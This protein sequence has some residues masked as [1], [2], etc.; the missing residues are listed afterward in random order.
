MIG[1]ESK[2]LPRLTICAGFPGQH[3]DSPEWSWMLSKEAHEELLGRS[4]ELA[5]ISTPKASGKSDNRST[6]LVLKSEQ[7]SSAWAEAVT[8]KS[9]FMYEVYF[10]ISQRSCH[11]VLGGMIWSETTM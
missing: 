6:R 8:G 1:S 11:Q 9:S 4:P 3:R 10:L 5:G 2:M 7:I